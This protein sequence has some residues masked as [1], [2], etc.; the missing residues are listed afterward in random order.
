MYSNVQTDMQWIRRCKQ[1]E[2]TLQD[3]VDD[4]FGDIEAIQKLLARY[5]A[6]NTANPPSKATIPAAVPPSKPSLDV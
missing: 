3:D 1:E 5:K 2:I 6:K 4:E